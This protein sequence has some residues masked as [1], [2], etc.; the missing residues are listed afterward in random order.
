MFTLS[1]CS[2]FRS[3]RT[4]SVTS[5]IL[6]WLRRQNG[7]ETWW[8]SSCQW[9]H[10]GLI[11]HEKILLKGDVPRRNGNVTYSMNRPWL[12]LIRML[13]RDVK[14]WQCV[15][16]QLN[17]FEGSNV[18]IWLPVYKHTKYGN[19]QHCTSEDNSLTVCLLLCSWTC[20]SNF[21]VI[22][23]STDQM[24]TVKFVSI[25]RVNVLCCCAAEHVAATSG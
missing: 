6:A 16:S 4:R 24:Q 5:Q 11:T 12:A 20:S 25:C 21:W 13:S 15:N 2:R 22:T 3:V 18:W 14:L 9:E 23:V 8:R 10:L 17:F 1:E 7:N 19:R